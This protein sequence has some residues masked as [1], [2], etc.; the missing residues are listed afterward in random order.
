MENERE[1][2]IWTAVLILACVL[3]MFLVEGA[4]QA[5]AVIIA[6]T[7]YLSWRYY[8]ALK[9]Y[10]QGALKRM[11]DLFAALSSELVVAQTKIHSLEEEVA[12]LKTGSKRDQTVSQTPSA[13]PDLKRSPTLSTASMILML[14]VLNVVVYLSFRSEVGRLRGELRAKSSQ[15]EINKA[16]LTIE[17][18]AALAPAS[19][20]APQAVEDK[21]SV[22]L[23][24]PPSEEES[25]KVL[26]SDQ[27][28]AKANLPAANDKLALRC[29]ADECNFEA[30]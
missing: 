21:T 18:Q 10:V 25:K 15:I 12:R 17:K 11:E 16:A 9:L 22:A 2:D 14:L 27:N 30:P 28:A 1:K 8:K 26:V 24:M 23:A 5:Y 20:A 13:R 3:V 29:V 19:V 4:A 7:L 6:A